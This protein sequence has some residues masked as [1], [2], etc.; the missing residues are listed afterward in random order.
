MP[1][2]VDVLL[3]LVETD[4]TKAKKYVRHR[5]KCVTDNTLSLVFS[6]RSARVCVCVRV[7]K[8]NRYRMY[9]DNANYDACVSNSSL[10]SF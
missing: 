1:D 7:F 5:D 2:M 6:D 8:R 10:L 9:L 4:L 3:F